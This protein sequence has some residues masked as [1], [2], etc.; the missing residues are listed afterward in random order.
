MELAMT[1]RIVLAILVVA[2]SRSGSQP[3][4]A[5]Q[6]P[7]TAS[8]AGIVYDP[9]GKPAENLLLTLIGRESAISLNVRSDAAGR[10]QAAAIAPG[11]YLLRTPVTDLLSPAL[12]EL[13]SGQNV[14]EAHMELDDTAVLIRVCRECKTADY[15]LPAAITHEFTDQRDEL[16]AAIL[17]RA[18]P[19]EGWDAF[20]QRPF[21]YPPSMKTSKL[22]GSVEIEGTIATDGASNNLEVVSSTDDRLTEAAMQLARPLRWHPARL[23]SLPVPVPLRVTVEFSLYLD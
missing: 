12:L 19:E 1:K 16:S 22:E 3:A 14:V 5:R 20:N 7:Q 2:A 11:P 4:F 8:L 9:N 13:K 23:R 15:R 21:P 10:F 6:E 18:E 17:R